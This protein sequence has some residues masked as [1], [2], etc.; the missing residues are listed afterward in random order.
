MLE[1]KKEYRETTEEMIK[2]L[3]DAIEKDIDKI[4]TMGELLDFRDELNEKFDIARSRFFTQFPFEYLRDII[5]LTFKFK[6]GDR[7]FDEALK[8]LGEDIE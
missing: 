2:E 5:I 4:N 3:I 6:F 8:T 7:F 1:Y